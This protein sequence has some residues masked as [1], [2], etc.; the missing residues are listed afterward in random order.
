MIAIDWGSSSLRAWRLDAAGAIV[1]TRRADLGALGHGEATPTLLGQV[2]AGWD[3][4]DLLLCGMVGARG[5]WVE[6]PY[7]SCPATSADLAQALLEIPT[8]HT[9]LEGRRVRVVPGIC[10]GA[11]A[12]PDVMRGE[13]TQIVGL[14][15]RQP[16]ATLACLPGTHSKWVSLEAGAITR[17]RTAM[18]GESYALYRQHSM[19]A[20]SMPPAQGQDAFEDEAF[21]AGVRR[22]GEPGGLLQ[23]LF[24]LRTLGLFD[25]L[26]PAQAPSY[27]SGLLIGHEVR[28]RMPLPAPVH[29][30]G[31]P[32]LGARYRQAFDLLGIDSVPHD[33]DLAASGLY[34]LSR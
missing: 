16:D 24:G 31:S 8:E 27:L 13:E 6:A 21:A 7:L 26:A 3:E 33:E 28:A 19:L 2:L 9:A 12:V 4:A 18:T 30:I 17:V 15:R 29:L 32:A 1:D 10:D 11:D 25:R 22:S 34:H 20:R 14:L 5:G 23:H